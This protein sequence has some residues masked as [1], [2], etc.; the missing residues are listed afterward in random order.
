MKKILAFLLAATMLCA[1][2]VLPSAAADDVNYAQDFNYIEKAPKVDGKVTTKEYG[3]VL[4]VHKYSEATSQFNLES[5]KT[6]NVDWD[7][8]FY[9]A[10]N[11]GGLYMAWVV[12]SP[13]HAPLPKGEFDTGGNVIGDNFTTESLGYMWMHSCVQ[14]IITPGA[15]GAGTDYTGN[16]LEVGFCE[17]E[18]HET[19]RI[20]WAYPTNVSADK[21]A[22]DKWQAKVVRDAAAE[23]T[24]YE[25]A[26]P[27]DMLGVDQS[28]TG[29]QFGLTYAVA[30]QDHYENGTASMVEWQNGVLNDKLPN[31]AAVITTVGGK[32]DIIDHVKKNGKI[33]DEIKDKKQLVIDGVNAQ[34]AAEDAI[35][36]TDIHKLDEDDLGAQVNEDTGETSGYNFKYTY[37][38]VL[39]PTDEKDIYELVEIVV[40]NGS[41]PTFNT[42]FEK[43]MLLVGFHTDGNSTSDGYARKALAET[44]AVGTTVGLWGIDLKGSKT[45][46]GKPDTLYLNSCLYVVKEVEPEDPMAPVEGTI[47]EDGA[48]KLYSAADDAELALTADQLKD[49]YVLVYDANGKLVMVGNNLAATTVPA[50]GDAIT[51][52]DADAKLLAVYNDASSLYA[53]ATAGANGEIVIDRATPGVNCPYDLTLTTGED[54]VVSYSISK[55]PAVVE[56]PVDS[57]STVESSTATSSKPATSATSSDAS[58]VDDDN[59]GIPVWVWIVIAVVVVAIVAVVVVVVLK[60]KKA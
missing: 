37:N 38:W 4:P 12:E 24:T 50:G 36:L 9:A 60:K 18:D 42:K 19:G 20:A 2:F 53:S 57:S 52:T 58:G 13:V 43:G 27:W 33:P 35:L 47:T 55:I 39:K 5:A 15:P 56:P 41:I 21:V 59:A 26:I 3:S 6:K 23:T 44:L 45:E 32:V 30:A 1:M 34:V 31:N 40:G 10:W 48:V 22:L 11:E 16:Y 28:G 17:L 49:V 14:F 51:F 46:S 54:G 25:I 7:F 8:S 29:A